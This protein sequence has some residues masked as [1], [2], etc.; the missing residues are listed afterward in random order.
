MKRMLML[1]CVAALGLAGCATTDHFGSVG[2]Q[3]LRNDQGHVI[4][5]KE[6]MQ[7]R[8]TGEVFALVNL[9]RP[10]RDSAGEVIRYEE[11]T[12]N[13]AVIRDLQ[14]HEI[15]GRFA[16]LRSRNTNQRSR[17][18]TIVIGSMD[19]RRAIAERPKLNQLMASLSAA[20]LSALR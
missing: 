17:G 1:V 12:R 2:R 20:D 19:T 13:G 14:G 3:A 4:G 10:V 15:G 16:D 9:F 8:E 6:M 5:Y 18:V 11:E 7:N